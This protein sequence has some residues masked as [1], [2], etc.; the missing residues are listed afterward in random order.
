MPNLPTISVTDEQSARILAAYQAKYGATT[1]AETVL[2][3]KRELAEH[4]K[5][6]VID[7][8][9]NLLIE[10]DNRAREAKLAALAAELPDPGA[11]T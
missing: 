6:V 11:I 2:A 5:Q 9:T 10:A 8:E 3:Y 7:H 4:V 1:T